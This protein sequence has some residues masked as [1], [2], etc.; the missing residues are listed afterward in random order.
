MTRIAIEILVRQME[1]AYRS[2]PF[3][4]LRKNVEAVRPE[5][6]DVRPSG[7]SAEEFGTDPELSIGDLVLHVAGAKHMYADRAFGDAAL[8]WGEIRLPALGMDAALAW[9]DD[10]HRMLAAGLAALQDDAEL[11]VERPAPWRI[12]MRRAHLISTII[13]HDLYRSGEINRQRALIRGTEGWERGA[14]RRRG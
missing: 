5:E 3:H 7:W 1:A 6:W 4:A 12:P 14:A 2:D 9:L 10:G 8:E 13:N 11:G